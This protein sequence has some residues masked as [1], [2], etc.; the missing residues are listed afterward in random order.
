MIVT[1]AG[2]SGSGGSAGV[3][4]PGAT[5]TPTASPSPAPV[6]T[7]AAVFTFALTFSNVGTAYNQSFSVSEA[8]YTGTLTAMS[9]DTKVATVAPGTRSGTFVV[10]PVGAGQTTII[11]TDTAGRTVAVAVHVTVTPVTVT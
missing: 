1:L 3:V 9:Q 7:P 10:T 2:C 4:T 6:A 11:V 8:G 5:P